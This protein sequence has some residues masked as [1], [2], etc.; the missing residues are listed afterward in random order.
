M[1]PSSFYLFTKE[2]HPTNVHHAQ[3]LLAALSDVYE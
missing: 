1:K 2:G 3:V